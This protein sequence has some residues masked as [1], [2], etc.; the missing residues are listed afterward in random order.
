MAEL[1]MDRD[2]VYI[3]YDNE[4]LLRDSLENN[5]EE[6]DNLTT[7]R[8]H[9]T[10]L[11]ITRNKNSYESSQNDLTK[12]S[13][14]AD[15][16]QKPKTDKIK[17]VM[18]PK[19]LKNMIEFNKMNLTRGSAGNSYCKI[20]QKKL[21][22]TAP[23]EKYGTSNVG[24]AS[25]LSNAAIELRKQLVVDGIL[26]DD[27][28]ELNNSGIGESKMAL[29]GFQRSNKYCLESTRSN[30]SNISQFGQG[31]FVEEPSMSTNSYG[32]RLYP[33]NGYGYMERGSN[34]GMF[35][36]LEDEK[37]NHKLQL[38][39]V[40]TFPI[41]VQ[42]A[43]ADIQ[44]YL[45]LSYE[46]SLRSSSHH[47]VKPSEGYADLNNS[48]TSLASTKSITDQGDSITYSGLYANAKHN[49]GSNYKPYT[50]SD[51]KRLKR[52]GKPGGLGPD[53]KS[54]EH[55]QKVCAIIFCSRF[56]L[57]FHGSLL[58]ALKVHNEIHKP[59]CKVSI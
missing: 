53:T 3:E 11:H 47:A 9:E 5:V 46:K 42:S 55:Q 52:Q 20:H 45:D 28:S 17:H 13:S 40:R 59:V 51:Y 31:Y 27:K 2:H 58:Q 50:L 8:M 16:E 25:G 34:T 36:S 21:G 4:E 26:T 57:T 10:D 18:K 33:D 32:N 43:P 6:C 30:E 35:S 7:V 38:P 29:S 12:V 15:K 54:E 56:Q 14:T 44:T 49:S 1:M 23:I 19:P 22:E 39:P 24:T 37:I 48:R 41:S